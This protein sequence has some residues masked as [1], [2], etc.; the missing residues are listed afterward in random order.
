MSDTPRTESIIEGGDQWDLVELS[1]ELEHENAKL[2]GAIEGI[3][4]LMIYSGASR[5]NGD[6]AVNEPYTVPCDTWHGIRDIVGPL[7]KDD[8]I[9]PANRPS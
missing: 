1:Q 9:A 8:P 3:A 4:A 5:Y 2:Q 7:A 6:G